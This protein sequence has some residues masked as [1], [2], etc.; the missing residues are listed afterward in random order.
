[1]M[2]SI[3]H[4]SHLEESGKKASS[5]SK[6][7]PGWFFVLS[8]CA[9]RGWTRVF[10]CFALLECEKMYGKVHA[11]THMW[12]SVLS[13]TL[14]GFWGLNS[15]LQAW[16]ASSLPTKPS[17]TSWFCFIETVTHSPEWPQ[18]AVVTGLCNHTH[19]QELGLYSVVEPMFVAECLGLMDSIKKEL[20]KIRSQ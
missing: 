6:N 12:R 9:V 19:Y 13:F 17:F 10:V 20:I 15:G 5:L 3:C 4:P 1:M 8:C 2:E 18:I 11:V 7:R 14:G 16:S